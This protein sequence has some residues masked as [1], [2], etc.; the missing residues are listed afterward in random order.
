MSRAPVWLND[1]AFDAALSQLPDRAERA[2]APAGAVCVVDGRERIDRLRAVLAERPAAIVLARAD[3]A[4]QTVIDVLAQAD[5]P[6]VAHRSLLRPDD[7][8]LV[9]GLSFRH[10]LVDAVGG[11]R[12]FRAAVVDA[13]GWARV[14][15]GSDL[16]VA[17][18]ARGSDAAV[19]AALETAS[20]RSVTVSATP[21]ATLA[22]PTLGVLGL[23]DRRLEVE[24]DPIAGIREVRVVDEGGALTRPPRYEAP[25]RLALR[26]ATDASAGPSPDDLGEL[27]HDRAVAAS[28]LGEASA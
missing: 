22:A 24:I 7:A 16:R 27:R 28:I 23:G 3:A 17:G 10:V 1:A 26:R 6:V 12:R 14:V 21:L 20:G 4:H 2:T 9:D 15:A 5:L 8:G 25:E 18:C 19:I 11:R 13:V